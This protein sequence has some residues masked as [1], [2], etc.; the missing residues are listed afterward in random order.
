[1]GQ[2]AFEV[3]AKGRG[4]TEPLYLRTIA[5]G[6]ES[7]NDSKFRVRLAQRAYSAENAHRGTR[8]SGEEATPRKHDAHAVREP[9]KLRWKIFGRRADVEEIR[10]PCAERA[11]RELAQSGGVGV[12]ANEETVGRVSRQCE[13]QA[14]VAR[15]Q[16]DCDLARKPRGK[17]SKLMIRTLES[18]ATNDVHDVTTIASARSRGK[19]RSP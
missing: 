18:F 9:G 5:V 7:E 16:V 19:A 8:D 1:M 4:E 14:A 6:V 11:V 13:R 10:H 3:I 2:S 15:A 12:Y 17:I